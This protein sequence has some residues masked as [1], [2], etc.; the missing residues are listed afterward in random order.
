M[1]SAGCSGGLWCS[2]RSCASCLVSIMVPILTDR[3]IHSRTSTSRPLA[4]A[5]SLPSLKI[6]RVPP[7]RSMRTAGD[8][9]DFWRTSAPMAVSFAMWA[10]SAFPR[11]SF[12]S[13]RIATSLS[14]RGRS[15]PSLVWDVSGGS[16]GAFGGKRVRPPEVPGIASSGTFAASSPCP[17]GR[18]ERSEG[19]A[20]LAGGASLSL[21][22]VVL[23]DV[24]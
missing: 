9:L 14:I 12:R 18:G 6:T 5:A 1:R 22:P 24:C 15:R 11:S 19:R 17:G 4:R 16:L 7:V 21:A 2:M 10:G 23:G 13:R 3:P 8:L 20:F